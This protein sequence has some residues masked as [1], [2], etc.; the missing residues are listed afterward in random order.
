[1]VD[2]R[3][4]DASSSAAQKQDRKF[5]CT[6]PGCGKT[7]NRK[8]YLARHSA[9]HL[10]VRPYQCPICPSQFARQDLLEKHMSTKAHE[11]RQ[12]REALQRSIQQL[13]Q[14]HLAAQQQSS[15]ALPSLST[16]PLVNLLPQGQLPQQPGSAHPNHLLDDPLRPLHVA[17]HQPPAVSVP[18][19]TEPKQEMAKLPEDHP[20]HALQASIASSSQHV[21]TAAEQ[22][23][24]SY[25][26]ATDWP[27]FSL[28]TF[29]LS[30]SDHYTWLFGSDFWTDSSESLL[31]S[32]NSSQEVQNVWSNPQLQ[33]SQSAERMYDTGHG[34]SHDL[35][36][37]A[38]SSSASL[39]QIATAPLAMAEKSSVTLEDALL[40]TQMPGP[41]HIGPVPFISKHARTVPVTANDTMKQY[42][43]LYW[44]HFD[45]LYPILHRPTFDPSVMEPALLIA[46]VTIG[47]A[48]STDR[49]ASTLAIVI[50]KK[51]RNIVFLMIEDQPQVQLWVHQ[52]LLLTN[53]FDKMLGSTVQYDMSQ[54]FHGTNIAL[55]HFSG[56]LKGLQEPQISETSDNDTA[57]HQWREW[58]WYETTK[59]TA[60]FAFICDTQHATLFRHSPI[61]SAFEVRLELPSTDAC[62]AA[63]DGG[64]FYQ[65]YQIQ[66]KAAEV[67]MM[68][69]RS[70]PGDGVA[71][72]PVDSKEELRGPTIGDGQA[73]EVLWPTFLHSLKRLIRL[74]REDQKEFHLANFSQFSCLI[75]LHGLLSICWDMQW[76][77]LLD[78]GIVSKRR[79]TEFK[80][81]LETSFA[82]WKNYFDYQL[83]KSNLPSI[84]STV[85]IAG[86]SSP[87]N[88]GTPDPFPSSSGFGGR[89]L[90]QSAMQM[91]MGP[92]NDYTYNSPMLCSNWAMFQLGLL[93]LHVDTMSLRINAGS[94]N[95]LGRK[96]RVIDR[97]N[98]NRAVHLWAKS[99]DGRL[100][101]WHSVQFMRR[102]AENEGLLDQAVH[103]PWGVYLATLTVWS[104]ERYQ[105]VNDETPSTFAGSSR[106]Y[107]SVNGR[108]IEYSLAKQDALQ[109]LRRMNARGHAIG[110][111]NP[112]ANSSRSFR[113]AQGYGDDSKD[114]A[115]IESSDGKPLVV[116]LVAFSA[117]LLMHIK[118]GFVLRG[119][120]V[121]NNILKEY[122][123]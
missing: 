19:S 5:A 119:C 1:M 85:M 53:Y 30:L 96:I 10:E 111:G 89:G 91:V 123:D 46:I 88:Q 61:L 102:I 27:K 110:L 69:F 18:N 17:P 82:N 80:N 11:K 77:G 115:R 3:S 81:R 70:N 59:R 42:L 78:M 66:C 41:G 108:N 23:S 87:R 93:A 57:D 121:L 62:W 105:E 107:V 34:A 86:E 52:T 79:M 43:N 122:I 63:K 4:R 35:T 8:D 2:K 104:Y 92:M 76:R 68:Q 39:S 12:K 118:W 22:Y 116:G 100:A 84:S 37:R 55:I 16:Q 109:Y 48:Y 73:K 32:R 95:V 67:G 44:V 58:V 31:P 98:S 6:H 97:E 117:S 94:P 65:M 36:A 112:Q 29:D 38:Y 45:A 72:A 99:E 49:E 56:Y 120:E 90:G 114:A 28:D 20:S 50:H 33:N 74:S 9:N 51:F 25:G 54:F 24:L 75:L 14:T 40:D 60:F 26:S 21:P 15:M 13:Q 71:K 106:K 64:E 113:D 47:M 7:F 83:S 103:I 101:A